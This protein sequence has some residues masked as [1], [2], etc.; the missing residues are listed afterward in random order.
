MSAV[1]NWRRLAERVGTLHKT[2]ESG[3]DDYA[4][5]ALELI[6][7]EDQL[8]AT[9]DYYVVE[10]GPGSELARSV[11]HVLHS[12]VAMQRC[13]ELYC[14]DKDIEVRRFAIELLRVIA[15]RRALDWVEEFLDNEDLDIQGWGIGVLDQ[16]A[17]SGS[18]FLEECEAL[19]DKAD[20]HVNPYVREQA[21]EIRRYLNNRMS[22]AS[23]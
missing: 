11:L 5:R 10:Q 12:W 17:F 13:Y 9:V 4:R 2:G 22:T 20:H 21:T 15:D 18:V 23:Q 3:G 6:I 19:L 8:R 7:G 14:S 1:I 16:L